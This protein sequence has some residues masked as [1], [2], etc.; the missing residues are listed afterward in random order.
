MQLGV[1]FGVGSCVVGKF[2]NV[3]GYG[4]GVVRLQPALEPDHFYSKTTVDWKDPCRQ[5][6]KSACVAHRAG[7]LRLIACLIA[8]M[9]A[10]MLFYMRT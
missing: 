1:W 3:S 5:G 7:I 9:P 10:N 2:A 6:I 8:F 4:G